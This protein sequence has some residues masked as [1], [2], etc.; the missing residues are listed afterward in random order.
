VRNGRGLIRSARWA[1]VRTG[2]IVTRASRSVANSREERTNLAA[3]CLASRCAAVS[4]ISSRARDRVRA[5][6]RASERSRKAIGPSAIEPY[7]GSVDRREAR[8]ERNTC[9]K[10]SSQNA[11]T[12]PRAHDELRARE[13]TT[14]C[15]ESSSR[16]T[17]LH[18]AVREKERERERERERADE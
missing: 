16:E 8:N 5:S 18:E 17:D 2:R 14:K 15:P 9:E 6:E 1:V 10:T 4:R 3:A 13:R 11:Y 7:R 12:T